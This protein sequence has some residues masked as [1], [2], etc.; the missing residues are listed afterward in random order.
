MA[1]C[2]RAIQSQNCLILNTTLLAHFRHVWSGI[3]RF[4]L[5]S[6]WVSAWATLWAMTV[7]WNAFCCV[8]TVRCL[9]VFRKWR[10]AVMTNKLNLPYAVILRVQK[11]GFCHDWCSL[12]QE[13][14]FKWWTVLCCY[15]SDGHRHFM[16]CRLLFVVVRGCFILELVD[17][18]NISQLLAFR[19]IFIGT[20]T[21][22]L[23]G[24]PM[25]WSWNCTYELWTRHEQDTDK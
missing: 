12:R 18:G 24:D 13:L 2:G 3:F 22:Q 21:E 6:Y 11:A 9:C 23:W 8:S 16:Q 5:P 4:R 25:Q 10:T 17:T 7:T 1:E 19:V 20:G 14:Q 15:I